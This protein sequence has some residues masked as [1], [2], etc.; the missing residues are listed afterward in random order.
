[1]ANLATV[2]IK[3]Q[4]SGAGQ[5]KKDTDSLLSGLKNIA[6]QFGIA[7]T[8]AELAAQAI[9]GVGKAIIGVGKASFEAAVEFD[10]NIRA[11]A[12]YQTNAQGL[13]EQ[14][15]RLQNI[16]KQPGLTLSQVLSGVTYLEAAGFSAKLAES[17]IKQF[18]NA[19]AL[20]GKGSQDLAGVS[21][22]LG[23]I[24]SKGIIS[25]EEV[26]QIAER[27]P[28]VRQ[29]MIAAFGTGSGKELEKQGK[30]ATQFIEGITKEL[31]KLPRA[32]QSVSSFI[33]KTADQ[34]KFVGAIIGKGFFDLFKTEGL[35]TV[36]NFFNILRDYA[37]QISTIFTALAETE[38]FKRLQ[39]QANS[40]IEALREGLPAF[41]RLFAAILAVGTAAIYQLTKVISYNTNFWFQL[42]SDPVKLLGKELDGI[43]IVW[44]NVVTFI[45]SKWKLVIAEFGYGMSVLNLNLDKF[46]RL[47]I[48]LG[49]TVS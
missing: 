19:L 8:A 44:S 15:G 29:A 9:I 47:P 4:S 30:T 34:F 49:I 38:L 22:A 28:Q 35:N 46:L 27:I 33:E 2:T 42:F 26:N 40:F 18:G 6:G 48:F 39:F 12:L 31:A 14:L 7:S 24:K 17:A 11:L 10:K 23:Q 1:M 45:T 32:Q 43:K 25:A 36:S 21:L 5:V 41:Q 3:F 37:K 16:A 13:E 20:A